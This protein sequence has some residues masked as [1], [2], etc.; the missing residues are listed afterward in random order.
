MKTALILLLA[1]A[2]VT[3]SLLPSIDPTIKRK[4]WSLKD[5]PFNQQTD[6]R[7]NT[8]EKSCFN[9]RSVLYD[10]PM[11]E[12]EDGSILKYFMKKNKIPVRFRTYAFNLLSSFG[13]LLD[14]QKD[15]QIT[16]LNEDFKDVKGK[17]DELIKLK[18]EYIK[19]Y[20][21]GK[22]NDEIIKVNQEEL[23]KSLDECTQKYMLLRTMWNHFWGK[24]RQNINNFISMKNDKTLYEIIFEKIYYHKLARKMLERVSVDS[25][26]YNANSAMMIG[27]IQE[28]LS[29]RSKYTKLFNQL[30]YNRASL[31]SL[32]RQLIRLEI[33]ENMENFHEMESQQP[34]P[35]VGSSLPEESSGLEQQPSPN[36]KKSLQ[37][38][39][40]L[41]RENFEYQK[42]E[43]DNLTRILK[44]KLGKHVAETK[45]ELINA[46]FY[47]IYLQSLK[48]FRKNWKKINK[49]KPQL[50]ELQS[51]IKI[52]KDKLGLD[53]DPTRLQDAPD[54][55]DE[56]GRMNRIGQN[57][58]IDS[59]RML[60]L[61]EMVIE[62]VRRREKAERLL[63][64]LGLNQSGPD[65]SQSSEVSESVLQSRLAELEQKKKDSQVT[66][67][68]LVQKQK[69][70]KQEIEVIAVIDEKGK[71][72]D[73]L[74][75]RA[76]GYVHSSAGLEYD[77]WTQT[78]ATDEEVMSP[79]N[80]QPEQ[81]NPKADYERTQAILQHFG[82]KELFKDALEKKVKQPNLDTPTTSLQIDS[83]SLASTESLSNR[84]G[85]LSRMRSKAQS[86]SASVLLPQTSIK[87]QFTGKSM[88]Q[89]DMELV[90]S[91][92]N[93]TDTDEDEHF[94]ILD[95]KRLAGLKSL[96]PRKVTN[97]EDSLQPNN[98][99]FRCFSKAQVSY[100]IFHI[101]KNNLVVH[102]E[103]FFEG[104]FEELTTEDAKR[105]TVF[106]YNIFM[107]NSFMYNFANQAK[108]KRASAQME[109]AF[110]DRR[111][112]DFTRNI[113]LLFRLYKEMSTSR[114]NLLDVS[115]SELNLSQKI[116]RSVVPDP[117]SIFD[118]KRV[119]I[120]VN[121]FG[122][123]LTRLEE[124]LEF[125]GNV[126][127]FRLTIGLIY[128][129]AVSFLMDKAAEWFPGEPG[130]VTRVDQ[131]SRKM[132]DR[133]AETSVLG[134]DIR[135]F[136]EGQLRVDDLEG[137]HMVSVGD[138]IKN[139][140]VKMAEIMY[141]EHSATKNLDRFFLLRRHFLAPDQVPI[142]PENFV[143]I[144]AYDDY[145][146]NK[147]MPMIG[148]GM[149]KYVNLFDPTKTVENGDSAQEPKF[150]THD[151]KPN[152]IEDIE[153]QRRN[154]KEI[155]DEDLRKK[156]KRDRS[157]ISVFMQNAELDDILL[158]IGIEP[159]KN[160]PTNP[161]F[162]P[163]I[164]QIDLKVL[165]EDVP[166]SQSEDVK[167]TTQMEQN[168]PQQSLVKPHTDIIKP[169][170]SQ[171]SESM[172][173]ISDY[174]G[175]QDD[176]VDTEDTGSNTFA[177]DESMSTPSLYDPQK[178]PKPQSQIPM[179]VSQQKP[180]DV[181]LSP[182]ILQDRFHRRHPVV[183]TD[184]DD[185]AAARL[186]S[187][188]KTS[189]SV[190]NHRILSKMH[191]H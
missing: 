109:K 81:E 132:L 162:Q 140:G 96:M 53:L 6:T 93:E 87:R 25:G 147:M 122:E 47:L 130:L 125:L 172:V 173:N 138:M 61:K 183:L 35:N 83:L 29:S 128:A 9:I 1:L 88:T 160:E 169:G 155:F 38:K 113:I 144:K 154:Q 14:E 65:T 50:M 190:R 156:Y 64:N 181:D 32:Q 151:L 66:I 7:I 136:V 18:I 116:L 19:A 135:F 189:K 59:W 57:F 153:D 54:D 12:S 142:E 111:T 112:R 20:V 191:R 133:I 180:G 146:S 85:Q 71:V 157:Q 24:L 55:M 127:L 28:R 27:F 167:R 129:Y 76:I 185:D 177:S 21:E 121:R 42:A 37:E 13:K 75:G 95:F 107:N 51:Q 184:T 186:K 145:K 123:W 152:E 63:R 168:P 58:E 52:Y 188:P 94:P 159:S 119:T 60:K 164:G 46:P 110:H 139:I 106:N 174:K 117:S 22:V 131:F 68:Y 175:D 36:P 78:E 150:R 104:F 70:L 43:V 11:F 100:L 97:D 73:R 2:R 141:D 126:V 31:N 124:N 163:D 48:N 74:L 90:R 105:F 118:L 80:P 33:E 170:G 165:D 137:S 82:L 134:T 120:D 23:R 176:E 5:D 72:I 166:K 171:T 26:S 99:R 41:T 3:E 179:G 89:E 149:P 98:N 91:I 15:N 143:P 56:T 45:R 30:L 17:I 84:T 16:R 40:E 44:K 69:D 62:V 178:D 187:P 86:Q 77:A 103:E 10:T 67:D 39:L 34:A 92:V 4:T 114:V 8:K 115:S 101:V 161:E 108:L 148:G 158:Q 49:L 182:R 79:L 102:P